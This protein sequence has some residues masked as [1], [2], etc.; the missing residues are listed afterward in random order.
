MHLNH[1]KKLCRSAKTGLTRL[2]IESDSGKSLELDLPNDSAP[3]IQ[4]VLE[5]GLRRAKEIRKFNNNIRETPKWS[6]EKLK[7]LRRHIGLDGDAFIALL[8]INRQTLWN[9]ERSEEL[10]KYV[11]AALE[12]ITQKKLVNQKLTQRSYD[13]L[14]EKLGGL[15]LSGCDITNLRFKLELTQESFGK[16]MHLSRQQV[17][18]LELKTPSMAQSLFVRYFCEPFI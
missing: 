5:S 9:Y 15:K 10:P 6:G 3:F 13:R 12:Y 8:E 18:Y 1:T 11:S 16:L 2:R 14:V 7:Y 17:S 4:E